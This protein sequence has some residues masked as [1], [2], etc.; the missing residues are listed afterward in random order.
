MS[1]VVST[2]DL[3]T[4]LAAYKAARLKIL[5][6]QEVQI[7]GQRLRRADLAV[8]DETISDIEARLSR[9]ANGSKTAPVCIQT[10]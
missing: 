10:R 6:G 2:A 1:Y 4:E 5:A 7:G 9:R 3:Q 8:V